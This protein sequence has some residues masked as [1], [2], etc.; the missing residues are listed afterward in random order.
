M[1]IGQIF[2]FVLSSGFALGQSPGVVTPATP[3][4][5]GADQRYT[6]ENLR[7]TRDA[8]TQ[9][10]EHLTDAQWH[11]RESTDRWSI[12]EVVEHL[13]RWEIAWANRIGEGIRNA[14]RPDL[15]P[16]NNGTTDPDQY[17]RDFIMEDKPHKAPDFARP[18]GLMS[19]KNNLLFF[20]DC[21][22]RP[23]HLPILRRSI[24]EYSTSGPARSFPQQAPDIHLPVGSCGPT[25]AP[26]SP[27]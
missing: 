18:S 4:W 22:T 3:I 19:G 15:T 6:V 5:T 12:A 26:D 21:V 27:G 13:G 16:V 14:P 8:L 24:C 1:K 25:P 11:F 9:E 10:V 7:R 23:L 17:F 2:F 20:W